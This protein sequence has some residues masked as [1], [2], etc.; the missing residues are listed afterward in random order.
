M[1]MWEPY[2]SKRGFEFEQRGVL[3]VK[4]R[5]TP[6]LEPSESPSLKPSQQ[7]TNEPTKYPSLQPTKNQRNL[8][9]L[10]QAHDGAHRRTYL[11][12][13]QYGITNLNL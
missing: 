2:L 11:D 10:N 9:R 5:L 13:W 6:S 8:L 7:P 3:K 4:E 12:I 1:K